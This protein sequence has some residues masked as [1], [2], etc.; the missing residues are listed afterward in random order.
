MHRDAWS[1]E[2]LSRAGRRTPVMAGLGRE[3]LDLPRLRTL[4]VLATRG[5]FHSLSSRVGAQTHKVSPH[6]R[7]RTG[8][9]ASVVGF[10]ETMC[11]N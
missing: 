6:V 9:A 10:G 5:Y 11:I 4:P 7:R 1:V 2:G 3:L 8:L